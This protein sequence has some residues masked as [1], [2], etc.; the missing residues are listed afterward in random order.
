MDVDYIK[1]SPTGNIT[2]LVLSAVARD[3]QRS[4]ASAL[5]RLESDAEQVGFI[6]PAGSG[7]APARLR[8]AGGEFCGNAA[9]AAGAYLARLGGL[10]EGRTVRVPLCVSGASGPV[11]CTVR[12]QGGGRF[13]GTVQMPL[14]RSVEPCALRFSGRDYDTCCVDMRGIFHI[15]LPSGAFGDRRAAEEALKVWSALF[16]ADAYGLIQFDDE[17]GAMTPLVFVPSADS[18]V[19]ERGCGSGTAAVGCRLALNAGGA[20]RRRISQPGGVIE[21]RASAENG[22]VTALSITGFVAFDGG[23]RRVAVD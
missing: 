23:V 9:M 5:T 6:E 11:A 21:V 3:S 22:A 14:P 8:M 17:S 4:V 1:A 20:V 10:V 13:E 7:G 16:D 15:L 18:L 12:T 19:W 2:L